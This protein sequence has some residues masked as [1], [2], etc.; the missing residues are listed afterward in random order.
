[1]LQK[2]NLYIVR[3]FWVFFI[4]AV[5]VWLWLPLVA[6]RFYAVFDVLF[7]GIMFIGAMELDLDTLKSKNYKRKQI[8]LHYVIC[9]II[10]PIVLYML[11]TRLWETYAAAIFLIA[12]TPSGIATISLTR[13]VHGDVQRALISAVVTMVLTPLVLPILTESITWTSVHID[14]MHMM[15]QLAFY[16]F[17]P[18]GAAYLISKY[19]PWAKK[20]CM[21]YA[22]SISVLL[23]FFIIAWPLAVNSALF[24]AVPISKFIGIVCMLFV[25]SIF[26]FFIWWVSVPGWTVKEKISSWLSRGLM[27]IS[28]TTLVATKYFPPEV[29][30][31]VLLYEFPRD[32]MLVPYKYVIEKFIVKMPK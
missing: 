17:V 7:F 5:V 4:W 19:A 12:A 28:F 13:L 20:T 10:G 26:L 18:L 21:P 31:I 27:S 9:C 8:I 2:I 32:I 6:Q 3:Y 14:V 23:I 25:V 24:L 11:S 16:I 15:I 29:L 22:G 30:L 1:M